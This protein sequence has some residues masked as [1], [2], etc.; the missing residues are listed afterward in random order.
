MG[1][2]VFYPTITTAGV[3]AVDESRSSLAG[4]IIYMFQIAGGSVG[5]GQRHR[6]PRAGDVESGNDAFIDG[7]EA[8]F[9][10]DAALALVGFVICVLLVGGRARM[11]RIPF[12]RHH[13]GHTTRPRAL[14]GPPS[15][16]LAG[17]A[18]PRSSRE[19]R[20][21]LEEPLPDEP[22]PDEPLPDDPLP[23]LS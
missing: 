23:E 10:L 14:A 19:S 4:A 8:A 16:R 15:G 12:H 17:R 13:A 22:L 5:L 7:I 3:T 11:P 2:G 20:R 21:V 9:K 1:V 18:R 6:L